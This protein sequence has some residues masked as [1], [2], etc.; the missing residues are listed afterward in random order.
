MVFIESKINDDL[1]FKDWI[2]QE[3]WK[4]PDWIILSKFT[5]GDNAFWTHSVLL[6]LDRLGD[7]KES[8]PTEIRPIIRE[9]ILEKLFEDNYLDNWRNLLIN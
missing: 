7:I 3:E 5:Y 4:D 9:K 2:A 8:V 1:L 6:Y